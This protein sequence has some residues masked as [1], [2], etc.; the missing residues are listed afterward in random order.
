M[1]VSAKV[2]DEFADA[3]GLVEKADILRIMMIVLCDSLEQ[4]GGGRRST[5]ALI[6]R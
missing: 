3:G 5:Q 4:R 6:A 2:C 1:R